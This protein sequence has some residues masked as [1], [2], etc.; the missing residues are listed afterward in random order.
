[1]LAMVNTMKMKRNLLAL[2]ITVVGSGIMSLYSQKI[3]EGNLAHQI[4]PGTSK[5][6][7]IDRRK[8]PDYML[9]S[10]SFN[11]SF[12]QALPWLKAALGCGE[13]EDFVL[14]RVEKDKLSMVHY[15]YQQTINHV[16]VEHSSYRIHTLND[17]VVSF[18]GS[19]HS[20]IQI[21]TTPAITAD[22]AIQAALKF[23]N[24][25]VYKWEL[26][27]PKNSFTHYENIYPNPELVIVAKDGNYNAPDFRLA[28]KMDVYAHQPLS[29][30]WVYVDAI[31]GT[32][33]YTSNRI[34]HVDAPGT[35]ITG[36]SGSRNIV[37]D[38]F[39][40]SFRLREAG[41]GNGI[42]TYD[43][44]EDTDNNNAVD[45]TDADNLWNNV[46]PEM[47]QYAGDA[48]WGAEMTYDYFLNIHGRNS[49]D[50]AGWALISYVHYDVNYANAFWDGAVMTYG[51]GNGGTFNAP[52][53]TIDITGHEITHGL[54]TFTA[55]LEY[56]DESGALNE[57]FSDIF[58]VT[59]DNFA[60]GTTGTAL[61]R[62]GEECTSSG[63]GI[64]LM[65]NPNAFGDPDTYN[66]TN[67]YT[68]TADNGGVHTNSGVQN[69]WYYL[70]CQGGTGTNDIGNPFNV[71]GIGMAD[72]ADIAFRNLTIY[73]DQFSNYDDARFYAIQSAQDLFG[74]CSPE[75]ETTTNA[76]YAV[77]V[78]PAYVANV[79]ADF[80][81]S[82]VSLC[83]APANIQFTNLSNNGISY[84]WNFGDGNTSTTTNP[85]HTYTSNGTYNIQL[86]ADGGLC[87]ID[88]VIYNGLV[89]INI[90]VAPT[91]SDVS[92][93]QVPSVATLN[94][95]GSG[96]L[97]WYSSPAATTP[98]FTG[99]PYITPPISITTTY[100]VED[101][102]FNG[103]VNGGP[104]TN[105]FGGGG[106]HNNTST[107][108]LEFTVNQPCTLNSVFVYSGGAGNRDIQ[109]WDDIGNLI[110]TYTIN[111]PG[112]NSTVTLDINLTPGNYRI[113]GTQMNLYRNNSGASYPYSIGSLIDITGSSAGGAFY[114]YFYDWEVSSSC[115]S[116]RIPV[117]VTI[118][119]PV[120]GFTYNNTGSVVNFTNTSTNA[121]GY[122]WDFGGG[123]TSN[124]ANPSF[125]FGGNGTF[126]V[127][128]I[129]DN[130]G[131]YDTLITNI[132]ISNS[133][134][135]EN[136]LIHN[137]YPNPFI[138]YLQILLKL[139]NQEDYLTI[140]AFNTLGQKVAQIYSGKTAGGEFS[141]TWNSSISIAPGVY[142]LH[143]QFGNKY[144]NRQIIKY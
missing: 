21:S 4:I 73:L 19:Y 1:M 106:N 120:A 129:V 48:H 86:I 66:G 92:Y 49:I 110:D 60:R 31:T 105:A 72:A 30:N 140:E 22:K 45:F 2:I 125:D 20:N 130:N 112:G 47:D 97:A 29:R 9:M 135:A 88:T 6:R 93:C 111:I 34:C 115:V 62:M 26:P 23:T 114:Y 55:N 128:L 52:L 16:P 13:N 51:D 61:W 28:W 10:A 84:S 141:T 126:P 137:I 50:N 143:I 53:T 95:I 103:F 17:R 39:G 12:Q 133:G 81:A 11:L 80:S 82:A 59:I 7:Y 87:G 116:A 24:A 78:G 67:W 63:N 132:T 89:D 98:L 90:P 144:I 5:L 8:A 139:P 40:G 83:S 65:S 127:T 96:T 38:S 14:K 100:Y 77:G 25:A 37:A 58:G 35:A 44:N 99:N 3:V 15:M 42:E 33:I 117:T 57:S 102:I 69:Y 122:L 56:Q 46:N 104:S 123:N 138:D 131:C 36:Y 68:G 109:L 107:Q 136:D 70:M 142:I 76:W 27:G 85:S 91:A 108:Y 121:S 74:G 79:T 134:I 18:N 54:T 43:M 101:Q 118:E 71:T 32:V 75:V 113:G 124:L 94:G 119:G 41:R 64:R